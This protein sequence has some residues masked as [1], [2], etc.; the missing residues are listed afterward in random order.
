[1][2]PS[3]DKQDRD[4]AR[5]LNAALTPGDEAPSDRIRPDAIIALLEQEPAAVTGSSHWGRRLRILAT[6]AAGVTVVLLVTLFAPDTLPPK[7]DA[8]EEA[9]GS[10]S[11]THGAPDSEDIPDGAATIS[12]GCTTTTTAAMVWDTS[13]TTVPVDEGQSDVGIPRCTNGEPS[14]KG[15]APQPQK[16]GTAAH[17][18]TSASPGERPDRTKPGDSLGSFDTIAA[19]LKAGALLLDVRD[20]SSYRE[21][22]LDSAVNVPLAQ[23]KDFHRPGI[24]MRTILVYGATAADSVAAVEQLHALGYTRV[25]SLGAVDALTL[26]LQ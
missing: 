9:F 20:N 13:D 26:P 23:L 16:G 17:A 3:P 15:S 11:R 1:M 4:I 21:G 22:H 18:G 24:A 6:M 19:Y 7:T 14:W 5:A 10:P 2:K 12:F 25:I 8:A